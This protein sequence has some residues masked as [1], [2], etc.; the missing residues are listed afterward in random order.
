M[1]SFITLALLSVTLIAC[2]DQSED[3]QKDTEDGWSESPVFELGDYEVIG[4][5]ERLAIDHIPFVAGENEHY[6][7]YFWGEQ[8]ELM[9]GPVKIEA[10]HESS[11]EKR[12][13][14]LTWPVLRMKKRY[15]KQL[16]R[17]LVRNRPTCL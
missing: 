11:E 2:S 7:I 6:V 4:K 1:I 5:E 13:Q 14:S 15:G 10:F 17:K 8:E 9:N 3:S 12:R 16:H